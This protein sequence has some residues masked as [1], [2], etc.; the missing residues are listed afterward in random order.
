M[1]LNMC[2]V[3]HISLVLQISK[4]KVTRWRA[5][6]SLNIQNVKK[7]TVTIAAPPIPSIFKTK[8]DQTFKTMRLSI[9]IIEGCT[10]ANRPKVHREMAKLHRLI[11]PSPNGEFIL[12][13]FPDGIFFFR[14]TY[15]I[16][17]TPVTETLNWYIID[18]D[19]DA[20]HTQIGCGFHNLPGVNLTAC[21]TKTHWW[22]ENFLI[23][24]ANQHDYGIGDIPTH[25]YPLTTDFR[26]PIRTF[27]GHSYFLHDYLPYSRRKP[28][29]E[30]GEYE[31]QV[32]NLVSKFKSGVASTFMAYLIALAIYRTP[33]L[34]VHRDALSFMVIPASTRERHEQRFKDFSATSSRLLSIT[35]GYDAITIT[36][37]R[38]EYKGLKDKDKTANLHF[39]ET[40]IRN[41]HILLFDDLLTSGTSLYQVSRKLLACG[42][43][44]VTGIF[45]AKTL[46]PEDEYDFLPVEIPT[47]E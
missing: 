20:D 26:P 31:K 13:L 4:I 47:N 5:L 30:V 34:M 33:N 3:K 32:Y 14:C 44:S 2:K 21:R 42:A 43:H 16:E 39:N 36:H 29:H 46:P 15:P 19:T 7:T 18:C 35:N 12:R 45:L 40:A 23:R 28:D 1:F 10:D 6:S 9:T 27:S 38:E 24:F 41:R 17:M 8:P 11:D 37:D 25:F 22:A